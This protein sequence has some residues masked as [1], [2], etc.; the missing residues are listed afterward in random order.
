MTHGGRALSK[1]S[2]RDSSCFWGK[3]Q[4]TSSYVN[5]SA[6]SMLDLIVR[7]SVWHNVFA[8]PHN[9]KAYE[10]RVLSGYGARWEFG[11][12]YM[13]FRGFVEP[14]MEDGHAKKW[15]H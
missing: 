1:H 4:G 6:D 15:R 3:V 12:G 2:I 7:N 13:I 5:A 11:E 8:L 10:I 14:P 9:L